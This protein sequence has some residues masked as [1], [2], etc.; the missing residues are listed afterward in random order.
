LS[1]DLLG[2]SFTNSYYLAR[3]ILDFLLLILIFSVY[4]FL[5]KDQSGRA[6][7]I[8]YAGRVL[9]VWYIFNIIDQFLHESQIKTAYGYILF[10]FPIAVS[11]FTADIFLL[12]GTQILISYQLAF[13]LRIKIRVW[14]LAGIFVLLVLCTIAL[15]YLF[16]LLAV[17]VLWLQMADPDIIRGVATRQNQFEASFFIIQF[18][19]TLT[20]VTLTAVVV[21]I[22][23][24]GGSIPRHAYLSVGITSMLWIRSF[25][26]L[27]IVI[28]Y[29]YLNVS[30]PEN[31]Y[32]SRD[33]IYG[34][35]TFCLLLLVKFL[36]AD[37]SSLDYNAVT[38]ASL[39]A[40]TR[41]H[42][43]RIVNNTAVNGQQLSDFQTV[44]HNSRNEVLSDETL[45]K[46]NALPQSVSTSL[47][48]QHE[49]YLD[50]LVRNYGHLE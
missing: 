5:H 47:R 31:L 37:P 13:Q 35:C 33:T 22:W 19:V 23:H 25:A 43:L 30:S 48:M 46:L 27:I 34:I 38:K 3:I 11:R 39:S 4:L 28:R 14:R 40:E 10:Y 16:S 6:T 41:T 32:V 9:F 49:K 42:L 20:M 1:V 12:V 17:E 8:V 36:L 24:K 15:Y 50:Q 26:E 2:S 21:W 7:E 45:T 29:H 44:V 18:L